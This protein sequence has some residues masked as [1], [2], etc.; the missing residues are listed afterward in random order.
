MNVEA[1]ISLYPLSEE[2]LEHPVH[3]FVEVLKTH[4]CSVE[5]GPMSSI[6]K[7]DSQAVF[8]ALRIGYEEAAQKGGVLLIVKAC[9]V[10]PL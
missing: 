6:V 9:N 3:D 8:E 4:G 5:I 1:E 2:H 10:C 7:G